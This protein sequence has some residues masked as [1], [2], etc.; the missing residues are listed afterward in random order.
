[1]SSIEAL[2]ALDIDKFPRMTKQAI[3]LICKK[4]KLYQT[5]YLNDV[6]YLHYKGYP[7]IENLD[8]YTG[9]KC[10]W[11]E[12][13]GIEKIENLENQTE[14]RSLYLHHNLIRRIENLELLQKLD[15][16]NLSHNFVKTIEHI[17][18]LP[19]LHTLDISHNKLASLEDIEH[20]A[21][22]RNLA[23]LDMS[24]NHLEDPMIVYV[25]GE[26]D[27]LR[28]LTLTGN[29]ILKKVSP[30][31]KLMIVL[32]KNLQHLD[33]MPVFPK[34]R[35]CAEAWHEGGIDAEMKMRQ[36]WNEEDDKR[37][38]DSVHRLIKLRDAHRKEKERKIENHEA[39]IESLGLGNLFDENKPN[40]TDDSSV[41]ISIKEQDREDIVEIKCKKRLPT[42]DVSDGSSS[43]SED[44]QEFWKEITSTLGPE[45]LAPSRKSIEEIPPVPIEEIFPDRFSES[46]IFKKKEENVALKSNETSRTLIEEVE[47]N[48]L[49][50]TDE[51]SLLGMEDKE[52]PAEFEKIDLCN[53]DRKDETSVSRELTGE[54]NKDICR[55][56]DTVFLNN[57]DNRDSLKIVNQNE[58]ERKMTADCI[59]LK[60]HIPEQLEEVPSTIV[61]ETII[62]HAIE[63]DIQ[64]KSKKVSE[65]H[66]DPDSS[67]TQ[68]QLLDTFQKTKSICEMTSSQDGNNESATFNVISCEKHSEAEISFEQTNANQCEEKNILDI[69][70]PFQNSH[71]IECV[72]TALLHL[73]QMQES[74]INNIQNNCNN[75]NNE[76][77]CNVT[78]HNL[79]SEIKNTT[80][81]EENLEDH[82]SE[83]Q[84]PLQ[85]SLILQ[86]ALQG[87]AD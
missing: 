59:N 7:R 68:S 36:K 62:E 64:K 56:D 5:P 79:C 26:M 74:I 77:D 23:V 69:N 8:E 49:P 65:V 50:S 9:L 67:Y 75:T 18:I 78:D 47:Y 3:R 21:R 66:S 24:H 48:A 70:N 86:N 46:V 38:R 25:L 53:L 39:C 55:D 32:C 31:R 60:E 35:A 13:N 30:Y 81:I 4:L 6:L 71:D 2:D 41:D 83:N 58:E 22:C 76:T 43:E 20:L 16:L 11:L 37:I 42:E 80:Q 40:F 1:M 27:N 85:K 14:L 82:V 63:E 57:T 84:T 54:M 29:P 33:I 28:V 73:P 17:E 52:I 15:T 45:D 10:L 12:C 72:P 87:I 19:V 51:Q 34:D 61:E 44:S